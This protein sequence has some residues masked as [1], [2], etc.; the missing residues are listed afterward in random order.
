[1]SSGGM[2]GRAGRFRALSEAVGRACAKRRT[3]EGKVSMSFRGWYRRRDCVVERGGKT[4]VADDGT[5]A[6]GRVDSEPGRSGRFS[7]CMREHRAG[8]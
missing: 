7:A 3:R 5:P 1:M 4:T 2:A 8:H 6:F